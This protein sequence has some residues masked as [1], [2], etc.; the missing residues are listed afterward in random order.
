MESLRIEEEKIIKDIRNLFR[1]RKELNYTAI[2]D[3]K[4]L[5]RQ[6]KETKAIKDRILRDIEN[7]S[8]Y[9]EEENYYKPVRASKFWSNYHIEFESNDDR[10]KTLSVDEYL[11]K[12]RPYLKDI[13]N[14]FKKSCTWE[15]QLTIANNFISSIYND[16]EHIMHS[17]S[18]K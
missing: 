18:D 16:E 15:I 5:L 1:L 9:E 6:K 4:N 12:I 10:N 3:I 7:L 2:K 11:N 13:I 14:N 8:E 17:K